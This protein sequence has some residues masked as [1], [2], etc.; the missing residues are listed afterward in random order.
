MLGI[1][2]L[3][4]TSTVSGRTVCS[5]NEV[6]IDVACQ[7][8]VVELELPSTENSVGVFLRSNEHCCACKSWGGFLKSGVMVAHCIRMA[9][10]FSY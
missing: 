10:H 6:D 8:S 3:L 2:G 9:C 7:C 5:E 4:P 1:A